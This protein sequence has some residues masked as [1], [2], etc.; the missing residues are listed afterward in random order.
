M[1]RQRE[2]EER[3]RLENGEDPGE[4]PYNGDLTRGWQNENSAYMI[5][6]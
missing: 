3:E 2:E 5:Y 1:K 6:G 4:D